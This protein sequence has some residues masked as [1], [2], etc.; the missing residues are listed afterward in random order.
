MIIYADEDIAKDLEILN[1]DTGN[2]VRHIDYAN[3]KTGEVSIIQTDEKENP[4]CD[5]LIGNLIR[6]ITNIN[7]VFVYKGK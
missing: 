5:S 2:Y 7:F 3:Q 4:L 1:L 6:C